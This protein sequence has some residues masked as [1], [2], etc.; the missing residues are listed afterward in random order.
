MRSESA[1][2]GVIR[3]IIR[4]TAAVLGRASVGATA[5]LEPTGAGGI[6]QGRWRLHWRTG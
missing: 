2:L 6:G 3:R 1:S 4:V 5:R